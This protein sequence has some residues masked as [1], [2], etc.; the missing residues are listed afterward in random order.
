M[1]VTF[2]NNISRIRRD[3]R[4]YASTVWALNWAWKLMI[5]VI[6]FFSLPILIPVLQIGVTAVVPLVGALLFIKDEFDGRKRGILAFAYGT[7]AQL[8][9][10]SMI[11]NLLGS[12]VVQ[13]VLGLGTVISATVSGM[14]MLMPGYLLAYVFFGLDAKKADGKIYMILVVLLGLLL[15]FWNAYTISTL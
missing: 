6:V 9:T 13:G 8:I 1:K 15:G 4:K 14:T 3:L 2:L 10:V 5:M 11:F 12:G 7:V